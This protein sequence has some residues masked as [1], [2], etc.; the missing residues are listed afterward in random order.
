MKLVL[1]KSKYNPLYLYIILLL[2]LGLGFTKTQI[3][4]PIYLHDLVL[5]L[6]IIY[7]LITKPLKSL[8]FPTIFLFIIISLI[9]LFYSLF[10]LGLNGELKIIALRQFMLYIY[11]T[12]AYVYYN[13]YIKDN[14]LTPLTRFL[15]KIG[16]ISIILQ[17]IYFLYLILFDFE[18]FDL[19]EGYN[20]Y[21]LAGMFGVINFGAYILVF[22]DGIVKW[23]LFMI[24]LVFSTLL[25]HS[26]LFLAVFCLVLF[27]FLIK[28]SLKKKII[29][30]SIAILCVWLLTFL[31]QF[32]DANASWRLLI[33]KEISKYVFSYNYGL[34]GQGF[35]VP[36]VSLDFAYELFYSI[37]AQGF[38]DESRHLE[39]WVS[40]PHNSFLTI[41]FHTGFVS[42]LLLFF[43]MIKI[44]NY[45]FIYGANEMDRN[46]LFLVLMLF[47]YMIWISFNVVL[48]LPHSSM[49]FWLVYFVSIEYFNKKTNLDEDI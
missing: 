22:K 28:I 11:L 12:V 33:W 2:F 20:Y 42:V 47:S 1:K 41:S 49:I 18:S 37:G 21:T 14:D 48:E 13:Q 43:P 9:Y 35:G 36:Y 16:Y 19:L 8:K 23:V 6:F 29:Y 5:L 26:S 38:L 24:T 40:P 25:G 7:S 30:L 32:Q 39:R 44:F 15:I 31:P 3:L 34:W 10:F 46:K 45:F 4:G 27:Y 17:V